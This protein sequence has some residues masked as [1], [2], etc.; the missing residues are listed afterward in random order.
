M[1]DAA[2]RTSF[3][4]QRIIDR[5]LQFYTAEAEFCLRHLQGCAPAQEAYWQRRREQAQALVNA[6]T[7]YQLAVDGEGA[8][9]AATYR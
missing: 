7:M 5:D 4:N 2:H 3:S 9:K 1:A 6:L 8:P